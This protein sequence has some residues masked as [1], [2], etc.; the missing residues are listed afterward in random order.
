MRVA[1]GPPH[2]DDSDGSTLRRP[3]TS[4]LWRRPGV[5]CAGRA[6]SEVTRGCCAM[7]PPGPGAAEEGRATGDALED[8][9]GGAQVCR[10]RPSFRCHRADAPTHPRLRHRVTVWRCS[11]FLLSRQSSRA[12]H[13]LHQGNAATSASGSHLS[14]DSLDVSDSSAGRTAPVYQSAWDGEFK[15][16]TFSPGAIRFLAS[17][18]ALYH[19]Y[20]SGRVLLDYRTSAGGGF[21]WALRAAAPRMAGTRFALDSVARALQPATRKRALRVSGLAAD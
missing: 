12:L 2:G 9:G 17:V 11:G 3:P 1:P 20:S 14:W 19:L 18:A 5:R 15:R 10:M 6:K 13:P 8:A 7:M 16:E 4:P 21:D